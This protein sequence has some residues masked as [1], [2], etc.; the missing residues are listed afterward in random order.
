[1]VDRGQRDIIEERER[2]V[3]GADGG[4]GCYVVLFKTQA[5]AYG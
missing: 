5:R 3:S 2:V 1:L 4:T